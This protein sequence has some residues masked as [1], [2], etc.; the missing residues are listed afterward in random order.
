[1][2]PTKY[3]GHRD[4][5]TWSIVSYLYCP[6]FYP[7]G[8]FALLVRADKTSL[9]PRLLTALLVFLQVPRRNPTNNAY[10]NS[11]HNE[12]TTTTITTTTTQNPT[13]S[14]AENAV[15][16]NATS[17]TVHNIIDTAAKNE[18]TLKTLPEED[19]GTMTT[20]LSK[21]LKKRMTTITMTMT[22]MTTPCLGSTYS[23]H[24]FPLFCHHYCFI[25]IILFPCY[26][27]ISLFPLLPITIYFDPHHVYC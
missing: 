8:T 19:S 1:M 26:D 3:S 6:V 4:S 16:D 23:I 7:S 20:T 10:H 17:A 2:T 5:D 15:D 12:I 18:N 11:P 14:D 13:S 21:P 24:H 27:F 9:L 25:V 22:T